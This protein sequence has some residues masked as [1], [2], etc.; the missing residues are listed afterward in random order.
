MRLLARLTFLFL[1]SLLLHTTLVHADDLAPS[2]S[3][4]FSWV[5]TRLKPT[6]G[7][8]IA[9]AAGSKHLEKE[10]IPDQKEFM[11]I[12]D[13]TRRGNVERVVFYGWRLHYAGVVSKTGRPGLTLLIN[14]ST[15]VG[16]IWPPRSVVAEIADPDPTTP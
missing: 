11:Q 7:L 15:A 5:A 13:S 1:L 4:S 12:T 16:T 14:G 8:D 3:G 6:I 2:S 10:A 9:M